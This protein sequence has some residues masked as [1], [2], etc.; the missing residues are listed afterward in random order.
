MELDYLDEIELEAVQKFYEN[1]VMREAVRKVLLAS[2]YKSGTLMKGV[3]ADPLKNF[4]LSLVAQ[5]GIATNEELGAD[6]RAI[7]AG[8]NELE[9]GFKKMSKV[10]VESKKEKK[11]DSKKAPL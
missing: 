2:I 4:A 8:V 9:M 5:K 6:L 7:W 10:Q 11:G 3:A 1:T